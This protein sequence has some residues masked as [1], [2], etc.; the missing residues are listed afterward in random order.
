MKNILF[1]C[2]ANIHRSPTAEFWFALRNPENKYESAGSSSYACR[3]YG[4]NFVTKQQME[5][6]DRIIFMEERNRDELKQLFPGLCFKIEVAGIPDK[7]RF[8][9]VELI[10]DLIDRIKLV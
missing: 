10:L 4:G 6:A 3:K 8:L 2:S 7:Y 9:Q 5:Q 1:V